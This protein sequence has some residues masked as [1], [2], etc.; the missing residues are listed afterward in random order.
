MSTN[1]ETN[2]LDVIKEAVRAAKDARQSTE[3][4]RANIH[5]LNSK[6]SL[7][8]VCTYYMESDNFSERLYLSKMHALYTWCILPAVYVEGWIVEALGVRFFHVHRIGAV[9]EK[10]LAPPEIRDALDANT[11]TKILDYDLQSVTGNIYAED[12]CKAQG[13][14]IQY[15]VDE[16]GCRVWIKIEKAPDGMEARPYFHGKGVYY[17][18]GAYKCFRVHQFCYDYY[19]KPNDDRWTTVCSCHKKD[20]PAQSPVPRHQ[21]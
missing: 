17:D 1:D 18:K 11:A 13:Q 8:P 20:Q 21:R 7:A 9:G 15:K 3:C 4:F 5:T 2:P 10:V 14:G 19:S 6:H 12:N 16:K